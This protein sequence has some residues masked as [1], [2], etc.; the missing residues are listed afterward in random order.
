MRAYGNRRVLI[1]LRNMDELI[2]FKDNTDDTRLDDDKQHWDVAILGFPYDEGTVINGGRA[3]AAR[4]PAAWRRRLRRL[5]AVRNP[6][7]NVDL[8][9]MKVSYRLTPPGMVLPKA[10]A[11]H[12]RR[13][14]AALERGAGAVVSIGGS[15]DQ[16]FA[17]A[18][19]LLDVLGRTHRVGV[20]NID[21]HLDVRPLVQPGDRAHSGSPFRLLLQDERFDGACLV[22]FAAQGEQC[23]AEHAEYV[24][25]RGGRIVWL[26]KDLRGD[27]KRSVGERFADELRYLQDEQHC[28]ALFVSFD[29]DSIASDVCPGVSC[30]AMIGLS[31]QEA[32]DIARVAGANPAVRLFD[33]SEFNPDVEEYRTGRLVGFLFYY[34]LLGFKEARLKD[35]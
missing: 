10:H 4:A 22:E 31:A 6:E 17:N 19:G 32:L 26:G 8:S 33:V 16:S 21:A 2:V 5:G 20:I 11:E 7:Y 34:F 3:G 15:N 24:Q 14:G 1:G 25:E 18:A 28:D 9:E 12:R 27:K 30:P 35:Q 29:I 23:S 13:V